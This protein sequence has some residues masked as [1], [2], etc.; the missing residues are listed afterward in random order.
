MNDKQVTTRRSFCR[1]ISSGLA[2]GA[3]LLKG[4]VS[5]AMQ[6]TVQP[7]TNLRFGGN[8]SL[9]TQGDFTYLGYYLVDDSTYDLGWSQG[10]THRYVGGQ[11]R[12]LSFGHSSGIKLF[13][14]APPSSFGGQATITNRWTD[15]WGGSYDPTGKWVGLWWDEA[16]QRLWTTSAIDYPNDADI[17][18]TKMIHTRTLNSNGSVSNVRGQIGLS[19][20][21]ARRVYGGAQAV[22]SWFQSKYGV[23]P[24]VVGWGGYASRMAQSLPVSLGPTMYAIPDPSG[25][26]NGSDIPA[27]QFKTIMDNS[28]GTREDDWYSKGSPSSF[29]RGIR[30]SNV[31]NQFDSPAWQSPAPDGQGRW[32]W[33]D[34]HYNTGCWIDGTSK[35]GFILVPSLSS[36]R[37][38]YQ[39]STLNWDYRSS[40]LHIYNPDHFG[41]VIN[42]SR[43]VWNVKPTS[44]GPLS[45]PGMVQTSGSGNDGLLYN[46]LGA[47]FDSAAKRL[48]IYY[49]SWDTG[50]HV[51]VFSVNC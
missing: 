1:H 15:I 38:W 7:P 4:S 23:G 30:N 17:S 48:Y 40:E 35:H 11:L 31:N 19:G 12:F 28:S 25:F 27:G 18:S 21:G 8:R 29:D 51:Y 43:A 42:G 37:A 33:G 47:S 13:E 46:V 50:N 2:A 36:G 34:S 14:F 24:Y 5:H 45:L 10:F 20:V 22:P 3:L 44:H 32:T 49:L 26:G 41:E 9:L 16:A 6:S 39:N